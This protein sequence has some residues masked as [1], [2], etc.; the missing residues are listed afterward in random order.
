MA[1]VTRCP[2]CGTVWLL[3]DAITAERGPVKCAEC[4]HSFDAT[5]DMLE[6]PD[7]MFPDQVPQEQ[8]DYGSFPPSSAQMEQPG[9]D[10]GF[11]GNPSAQS[12]LPE[13]EPAASPMQ[14]PQAPAPEIAPA[15]R[16][17]E[18]IPIP[19][20]T[21]APAAIAPA[22]DPAQDR[23]DPTLGD[24][25]SLQQTIPVKEPT[26]GEP[27]I[28][29]PA[30]NPS[31]QPRAPQ[32]RPVIR[33]DYE[34]VRMHRRPTV[35]AS[36]FSVPLIL[37]LVVLSIAI[38][39]VILNQKIIKKY[40][41]SDQLFSRVCRTVPC[42]GYVFD[43]FD[44][45]AVT[46]N[47][48]RAMDAEHQYLL[49]A[50]LTNTSSLTQKLPNLRVQFLDASGEKLLES[51]ITPDQYTERAANQNNGPASLPGGKTLTIRFSLSSSVAPTRSFVAPTYAPPAIKATP[52][53][54]SAE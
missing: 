18:G 52:K 13:P 44:A 45:F 33:A 39:A 28:Q 48:I 27:S 10:D 12:E 31:A 37:L 19:A 53:A 16:I 11:A 1:H 42:P 14:E 5:C 47:T 17:P 26:I 20:K 38:A 41:V 54:E 30:V 23:Q 51:T 49:E 2:Y 24:L 22:S 8:T 34:S 9:Q 15:P 4:R 7:N 6:V 35:S 40:P 43:D 50:S 25:Q 32:P 21:P 36:S 29:K 46:K 3:P